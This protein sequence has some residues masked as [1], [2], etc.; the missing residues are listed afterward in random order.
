MRD[1]TSIATTGPEPSW[2]REVRVL[3]SHVSSRGARHRGRAVALSLAAALCLLVWAA[4]AVAVIILL[5]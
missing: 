3:P 1:P 2:V 5:H 4:V